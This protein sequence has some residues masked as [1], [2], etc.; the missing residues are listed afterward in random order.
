VGNAF[1]SAAAYLE[2][3]VWPA[4]LAVFYPNPASSPAGLPAG[5][6]LASVLVIAGLSTVAVWQ[7]RRRPYL[8]VGWLWFT[9]TLLPVIG[10][11]QVG[12]QGMAD[13]YTYVPLI[14]V[15]VALVWLVPASWSA[16]RAARVALAAAAA[17]VLLALATVAR[18]QAEHWR[19]SFSLF[20]HAARVTDG[21]WLAWKNLGVI[22]HGR[23]ET[24]L[25]LDAFRRSVEA[26]PGEPDGWFN[27]G[28]EYAALDRHAEAAECFRRAVLLAPEDP[29]SWFALGINRALLGRAGEANEAV[30]RLRSIDP[31]KA[32]ELGE[33]VARISRQLSA[34]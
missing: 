16:A 21:N 32:Q 15:F 20:E 5:R 8:L 28:T 19:D 6:V 14:G 1:L 13:R 7:V 10:I 23:G 3:T 24:L 31:A 29:E 12:V 4:G 2:K 27:L 25:A 34:R 18:A 33:L 11:V 30:E 17:A 26:R 9:V 22:H